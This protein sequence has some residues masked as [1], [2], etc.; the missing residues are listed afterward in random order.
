MVE[1][2]VQKELLQRIRKINEEEQ[3]AEDRLKKEQQLQKTCFV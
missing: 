2:A 3:L 1:L